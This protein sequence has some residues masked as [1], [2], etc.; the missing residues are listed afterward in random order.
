MNGHLP[1]QKSY[2]LFAASLKCAL[3][4]KATDSFDDTCLRQRRG[5]VIRLQIKE[6]PC[7]FRCQSS[8]Q[9]NRF[10]ESAASPYFSDQTF[11]LQTGA[12]QAYRFT[13]NA[14]LLGQLRQRG[15]RPLAK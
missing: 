15:K 13:A 11:L 4:H 12:S 5:R 14:E 9:A 10:E 7:L 8:E 6:H 3:K 1:D 2:I